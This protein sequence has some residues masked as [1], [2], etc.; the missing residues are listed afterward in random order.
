[1]ESIY[2]GICSQKPMKSINQKML[3]WLLVGKGLHTTKNY[4]YGGDWLTPFFH[5]VRVLQICSS[6]QCNLIMLG[7]YK[8]TFVFKPCLAKQ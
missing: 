5:Q 3:P 4:K 7:L 8:C 2:G 1:M 6:Q